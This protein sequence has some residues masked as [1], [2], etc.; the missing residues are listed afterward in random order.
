MEVPLPQC[1]QAFFFSCGRL[2]EFSGSRTEFFSSS[3][4]ALIFFAVAR[5][6][7]SS[8]SCPPW[9][10]LFWVVTGEELPVKEWTRD[11]EVDFAGL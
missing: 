2:V 10:G 7:T 9:S 3:A 4:R 6:S 8:D 11:C 1:Q 5:S